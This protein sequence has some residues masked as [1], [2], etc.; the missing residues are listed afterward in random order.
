MV[1]Y[2]LFIFALIIIVGL[3]M[4]AVPMIKR[5]SPRAADSL[6]KRLFWGIPTRMVIE[7]F[8]I[9]ALTSMHNMLS[10]KFDASKMTAYVVFVMLTIYLAYMYFTLALAFGVR[11]ET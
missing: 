4:L 10:D 3:L 2:N 5:C 1:L 8:F 11:A 7:F 6:S 9:L